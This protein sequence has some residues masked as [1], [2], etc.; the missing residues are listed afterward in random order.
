MFFFSLLVAIEEEV[1]GGGVREF[2]GATEA[3]VLD[4]EKLGDGFDLRIDNAKVEIGAGAGED[5]SLRNRVCE[6]VGGA[7]KLCA[8]VA[9]RIGDGEKDA[10]K[11]GTAHLIFGREISAAEKWLSVGD[12]KTGERPAALAG[13]A[14]NGGLYAAIDLAS[15]SP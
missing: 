4:V 15:L 6:G 2:G 1:D 13:N 10:A 11:S 3:A 7:F 5:F 9:V 12:Q 14:P 8:L